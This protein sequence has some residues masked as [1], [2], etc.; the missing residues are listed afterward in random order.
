MKPITQ[1][2]T[3]A[4]K[5]QREPEE[6]GSQKAMKPRFDCVRSTGRLLEE[7][8]LTPAEAGFSFSHHRTG[9]QL[10]RDESLG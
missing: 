8:F 9:C 1:E 3:T 6:T 2:G 7:T 10:Q 5:S 4:R